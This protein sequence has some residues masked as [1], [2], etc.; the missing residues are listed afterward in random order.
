M[1]ISDYINKKYKNVK[2]IG[3]NIQM[4]CPFHN[5]HPPGHFNM[6]MSMGLWHCY[7]S[8]CNAGG[9]FKKFLRLT[10]DLQYAGN[11]ELSRAAKE[12]PKNQIVLRESLLS[13]YKKFPTEMLNKG[14][15]SDLLRD[16]QIYFDESNYRIIFPIRDHLGNLVGISG[17]AAVEGVYPRYKIYTEELQDYYPD[18]ALEKSL[19]LYNLDEVYPRLYFSKKR[20]EL[21]I[22]EGFKACLWLLQNGYKNTIALMGSTLSERQRELLTKLTNTFTLFLDNDPAG[23]TATKRIG[24]ILSVYGTVSIIVGDKPQPDD[25]CKNDLNFVIANKIPFYKY[26]LNSKGEKTNEKQ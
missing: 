14:F 5:D 26:L 23:Q 25:Y 12:R 13:G 2:I 24:S 10:G 20:E 9:T 16:K 1:N 22:V 19:Y 17:R 11:I 21:I 8:S 7:H 3:R 6:D 4:P 15:S 18:Y